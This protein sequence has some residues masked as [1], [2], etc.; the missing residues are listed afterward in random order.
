MRWR[1]RSLSARGWAG[2]SPA[3]S[4]I[5][6]I[7]SDVRGQ[8]GAS[9]HRQS[10]VT[11]VQYVMYGWRCG[12]CSLGGRLWSYCARTRRL[13]VGQRC[14]TKADRMV[15]C[16]RARLSP[17][18]GPHGV[19]GGDPRRQSLLEQCTRRLARMPLPAAR[20]KQARSSPASEPKR[21]VTKSQRTSEVGRRAV[22]TCRPSSSQ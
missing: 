4:S 16:I 21:C 13:Y 3:V 14:R 12:G 9:N 19:W 1:S 11:Y 22:D 5:A 17:V 10:E 20:Q 18:R 6:A 8:I 7:A 2:R 15:V